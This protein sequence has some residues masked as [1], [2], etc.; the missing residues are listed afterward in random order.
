MI[1]RCVQVIYTLCEEYTLTPAYLLSGRALLKSSLSCA[2][3]L[4]IS[5]LLT[6]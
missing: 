2:L 5:T 4:T 6:G 3:P 1:T